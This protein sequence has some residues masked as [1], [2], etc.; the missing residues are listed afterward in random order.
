MQVWWLQCSGVCS[1]RTAC[2]WAGATWEQPYVHFCKCQCFCDKPLFLISTCPLL[3]R[4]CVPALV[5][6]GAFECGK[7]YLMAQV[8]S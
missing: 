8:R 2:R 4:S 3:A 5:A 1:S 6:A 7:R